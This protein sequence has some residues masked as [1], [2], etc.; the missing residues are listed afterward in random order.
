M[1]NHMIDV[2]DRDARRVKDLV[3]QQRECSTSPRGGLPRASVNIRAAGSWPF[4]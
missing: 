4:G 1:G 2:V 3:K